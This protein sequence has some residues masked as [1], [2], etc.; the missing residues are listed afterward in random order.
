MPERIIV[1]FLTVEV[2]LVLVLCGLDLLH[3]ELDPTELYGLPAGQLELVG[4]AVDGH[5]ADYEPELVAILVGS[6]VTLC[7]RSRGLSLSLGLR[8]S[9]R[10]GLHQD[11]ALALVVDLVRVI[12][13]SVLT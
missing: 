2:G 10:E 4:L 12:E 9:G 13:K 1:F 5:V 7:V 8:G 11:R 3:G 6:S